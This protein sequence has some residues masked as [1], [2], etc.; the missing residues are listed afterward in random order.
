TQKEGIAIIYLTLKIK[1]RPLMMYK[2]LHLL[3]LHM[4][5][6]NALQVLHLIFLP[7]LFL[8]GY[9]R[10]Q[11]LLHLRLGEHVRIQP[12]GQIVSPNVKSLSPI[13]TK[14]A[15]A[16]VLNSLHNDYKK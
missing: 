16:L 14:W 15:N 4:L 13:E 5:L 12:I 9:E 11:V 1:K 7:S 8:N 2:R 6:H 10:V 3:F